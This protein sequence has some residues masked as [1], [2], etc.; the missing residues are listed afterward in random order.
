MSDLIVGR[1]VLRET[2]PVSEA[3]SDSRTLSL[4]GREVAPLIS[5]AQVMDRHEHVLGL[6]GSLVQVVWTEKPERNGY[7]TVT[8]ANSD[9]VDRRAGIAWANWKMELVKHGPDSAVDLESRLI[10]A[11]RQNDFSLTGER[12]HAPP[13]AHYS[14]YT[15]PT[16]PSTM[17]RASTDGALTVYRGV[18]A[19]VSPR[20]G[21]AV[22]DYMRGRA[23]V[24]SAGVERVGT[25]YRV[26]PLD[27]ELSNGLVRVRPLLAAGTLEVASF[28]AGAWQPK[29]WWVDIGG[30]QIARIE[31][32]TILRNDPEQCIVRLTESR[33]PVGRA[34]VDLTL[35]RGARCVEGYVQRGDSGTISVYLATAE[36]LTNN[37]SYLVRSTDDS[38]SNRVTIGSARSYSAHANGGVTK[39]SVTALDFYAGVV[40]GGGTA[41]S[42]DTAI[43]LRNQY[44]GAMPETTGAV[45]R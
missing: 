5:R 22:G 2:F 42:G 1:L 29:A 35:R 26:D 13:P 24:L 16:S 34:V 25:G 23:R 6:P 10:G 19:G 41:V 9:L 39:T 21:C 37:T 4:Q 20:W 8:S 7:Y 36:T 14:Y 31:A 18:P 38:A 3:S 45:R 32:A 43:D 27:W 11:V 44:I 40:V 17:T 28:A 12:W 33:S 15:G 30:A